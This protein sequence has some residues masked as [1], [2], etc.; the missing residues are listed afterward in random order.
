MH[1]VT[2]GEGLA[3]LA[4]KCMGFVAA[5]GCSEVLQVHFGGWHLIASEQLLKPSPHTSCTA[6]P[7]PL[8]SLLPCPAGARG[9]HAPSSRPAPADP[10]ALR[11]CTAPGQAPA[12]APAHSHH[13]QLVYCAQPGGIPAAVENTAETRSSQ[14]SGS[15]F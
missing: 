4:I 1:P 7:P 10:S 5:A 15:L 3:L 14:A 11:L 2:L 8:P 6:R 12:V 13:P 9:V